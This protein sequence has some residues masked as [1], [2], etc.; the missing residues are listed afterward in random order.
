MSTGNKET[1][2]T[3]PES[4]GINIREELLKFHQKWYSSNIMSL[5]VVGKGKLS[6]FYQIGVSALDFKFYTRMK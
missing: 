4:K 2:K 5:I 3:I 1:L 6:Y